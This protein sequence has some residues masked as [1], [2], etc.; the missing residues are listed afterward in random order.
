MAD[1]PPKLIERLNAPASTGDDEFNALLPITSARLSTLQQLDL[2]GRSNAANYYIE[3][4]KLYFE[5]FSACI[6]AFLLNLL[7]VITYGRIVFPSIPSTIGKLS[8]TPPNTMVMSILTSIIAQVC[9]TA[10]SSIHYGVLAGMMVEVIPFYHAYFW[11]IYYTLTLD[12]PILTDLSSLYPTLF[13]MVFISSVSIAFLFYI[14]G[15]SFLSKLLQFF[16]RFLS[17]SSA[18][19]I[20]I[21]L[22]I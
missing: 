1:R 22:F 11:T 20:L 6:I 17:P 14:L 4:S 2:S 9:F 8:V 5:V 15:S 18:N 19:I 3:H 7:D 21:H 13:F 16:P 12:Q 10:F